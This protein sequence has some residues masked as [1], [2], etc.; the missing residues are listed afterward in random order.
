MAYHGPSYGLSRECQMK[1]Q[2]KFQLDRAI[3][4][5]DWVEAVLG[6]QLAA[7]NG[8]EPVRPI[9]D[10]LDFAAPLKDG[11]ALCDLIN[12][13]HPGAVKKVNR[14]KTPF[15]MRENLEMFLKGCVAYGLKNQDLF[16]VNDLYEHRNLY[17]VVDCIFALGGLAQKF[18]FDGPVIGVKVSDENRRNFTREQLAASS[19]IIGLQYGSNSGASQRGMTA[20]GTTRQI[21]P[22]GKSST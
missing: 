20:Y 6:R 2:A 11:T 22:D 16:Q 3:E 1:A 17:M 12:K 13:L 15:M 4:A 7:E 5:L 19:K 10:Q 18:G 9:R 14:N 21:L 8:G